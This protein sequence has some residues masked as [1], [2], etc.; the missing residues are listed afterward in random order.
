MDEEFYPACN[1]NEIEENEIELTKIAGKSI[2]LIKHKGEIFAVGSRCPH[3]GC[4]LAEGKLS[5]YLLTC[6]CHM[7]SFDI[8]TGEYQVKKSIKLETYETKI[9]NG[10]ILVK[11]IANF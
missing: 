3:M 6:P 8:R 7:W 9:E 2:L 4:P 11:P 1:F 10:K 5:E